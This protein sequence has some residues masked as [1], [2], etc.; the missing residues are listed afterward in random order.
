MSASDKKKLRKEER[1][2]QLTERQQAEQKAAKHLKTNT[3]IFTAVV[4]LVLCIGI[5]LIGY[6]WYVSSGLPERSTTAVQIGEHKLSAAELNYYYIDHLNTLNQDWYSKYLLQQ[7]GFLPSVALDQQ[8]YKDE[9][10]KTWGDYFV[11]QAINEAS[12]V[13]AMVDEAGK[14][15]YTLTDE[16][17]AEVEETITTL[18]A[19]GKAAGFGSLQDYLR[20][21]YG[22]GAQVKSFRS[23]LENVTLAQNYYTH[24]IDS[25]NYSADQ[26][27]AKE[28]ETPGAF[29]N[30]DFT[31]YTV[32]AEDFLEH[33][34][35]DTHEHSE[36]DLTAALNEAEA[37]AKE[38]VASKASNK[39]ELDD[40]IANLEMYKTEDTA[41]ENGTPDETTAEETTEET[42][43]EET[44]PTV[45]I[46]VETSEE[47][48][49]DA[50][51]EEATTEEETTEEETTSKAPTSIERDDYE[52][53][54]IPVAI[55]KWLAVAGREEGEISYVPYY[56]TDDE[57]NE[58][59]EQEGYYVVIFEGEDRNEDNL[60]TVRHI[61]IGF[62][63]G[64]VDEVTGET[65]YSEEEKK[66]AQDKILD[67]KAKYEAG[68]KT[69]DTFA[70][71]AQEHSQD[72]ADEGGLYDNVYPG[73]MVTNFND[74]IFDESR[75]TGDVAEVE[76]EYGWH[77]IYFVKTEEKTHREHM[78]TETLRNEDAE[79]WFT[80]LQ[81]SYKEA[82]QV[83][84]TSYLNQSIVLS[85]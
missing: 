69:E 60:V 55:S 44:E 46:E 21:I 66:A 68:E 41:V 77:L 30:F 78:I 81:N 19:Q 42:A 76:T 12:G 47:N 25:L 18:E 29:S 49:E 82:A 65:V 13:L 56:A 32:A 54:Y 34:D 11:D 38:L 4:A 59:E 63:G 33:D 14:A 73:E 83:K 9:A 16:A 67:I 45:E 31:Y 53:A 36:E 8:P 40:A 6:N 72:N 37:I 51:T 10:G 26:L 75:K 17:K 2:A 3:I 61:L 7:E 43:T 62:E 48:G 24:Y 64:T 74:W 57:G 39:Q 15:G 50:T 71:L 85:Q 28:E 5:G 52:Y 58:T 84:N 80:D 20:A 70:K 23:Y 22:N 27:T 35:E 79:V 1:Q